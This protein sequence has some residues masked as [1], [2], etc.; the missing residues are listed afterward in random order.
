MPCVPVSAP[1]GPSSPS[2]RPTAFSTVIDAPRPET[3]A[4]GSPASSARTSAGRLHRRRRRPAGHRREA[5]RLRAEV[6]QTSAA[7]GQTASAA[8]A[9]SLRLRQHH[10]QAQACIAGAEDGH[11][12]RVASP[13]A[14]GTPP[15][16][17]A[18]AQSGGLLPACFCKIP[19]MPHIRVSLNSA[20]TKKRLFGLAVGSAA[21]QKE[22]KR[23]HRQCRRLYRSSPSLA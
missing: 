10:L 19:A 16:S 13:G 18:P 22:T 5:R 9:G 3:V 2:A 21:D 7:Q 1:T 6:V 8:P 12:R 4:P 20:K 11:P 23:R 15:W 17:A 14:E